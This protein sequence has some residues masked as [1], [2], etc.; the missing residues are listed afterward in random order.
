MDD[1]ERRF[2]GLF[3]E[4]YRPL[5]AYALRRVPD[6]VSAE[7]VV[8]ETFA[9]AWR[10]R[11]TLPD[12][13]RARPYLFGIAGRVIAN[14]RRSRRRWSRLV[15][16]LRQQP[17]EDPEPSVSD[18]RVAAALAALSQR[19]REVLRLAAWDGLAYE[20]IAIV[21]GLS[22]SGVA[23]RLQR[24]RERLASALAAAGVERTPPRE[25]GTR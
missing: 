20:D 7:D 19:D 9:I 24:A 25:S 15:G 12:G 8:A 5:M 17:I 13:N 4:A 23:S 11:G 2:R 1:D 6:R 21:L 16:R 22:E 14:E 18:P 3:D 10:R